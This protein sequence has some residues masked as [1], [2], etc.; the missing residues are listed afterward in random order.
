M[1]VEME[2][3]MKRKERERGD[4][5]GLPPPRWRRPNHMRSPLDALQTPTPVNFRRLPRDF[6]S[7]AKQASFKT[8]FC[9]VPDRF[10]SEFKRFGEAKTNQKSISGHFV[11]DTF[12]DCVF[13]SILDAF[14]KAP[15][16]KN[17]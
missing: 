15:T 4:L 9:R 2:V 1:K 8:S 5:R 3:E 14:L 16:L 6:H 7:V 10:W 13:A 12:F 11:C 17:Q